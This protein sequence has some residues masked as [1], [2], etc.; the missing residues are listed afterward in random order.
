LEP[1]AQSIKDNECWHLQS[2]YQTHSQ[3]F[4]ITGALNRRIK[5]EFFCVSQCG[6]RSS[7]YINKVLSEPYEIVT[8]ILILPMKL[9]TTYLT[10]IVYAEKLQSWTNL[11]TLGNLFYT[12][13]FVLFLVFSLILLVAMI[14]AIVLTMHKTTQIKRQDM[15]RQN[16]IDFKNTIKK[17]RDI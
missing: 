10:Y 9:S 7:K 13:Y 16:A 1:I 8:Y 6:G 5:Q 14:G 2:N 3:K 12:T 17:I 15:F 11:E 4:Y